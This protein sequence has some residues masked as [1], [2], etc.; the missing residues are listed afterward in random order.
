MSLTHI[1][2]RSCPIPLKAFASIAIFSFVPT[3]SVEATR[4]GSRNPA[5]F[6]SNR[7]PK[8]PRSASA[9]A[10]RVALANGAMR[11]TRASPA[12]M[13]TPASLYVSPLRPEA[14]G[15]VIE[16]G[17]DWVWHRLGAAQAAR[18][19]HLPPL[20]RP[21]CSRPTELSP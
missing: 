4:T 21:D 10:R 16:L 12:S 6:R 7:P 18:K 17:L 5:A 14:F 9:P 19:L 13:S 8:P 3:P 2:T 11:A 15:Q 20:F 1:A